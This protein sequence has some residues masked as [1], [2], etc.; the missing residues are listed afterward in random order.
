MSRR[1]LAVSAVLILSFCFTQLSCRGKNADDLY[2]QALQLIKN[3]KSAEAQ[4]K[5]LKAQKKASA[6]VREQAV[7]LSL[8]LK[9][10]NNAGLSHSANNPEKL[11]LRSSTYQTQD[12]SVARNAAEKLRLLEIKNYR[13]FLAETR[14]WFSENEISL[15]HVELAEMRHLED[16]MI[17]GRSAVFQR[18]YDSAYSFFEPLLTVENL[19]SFSDFEIDDI[20]KAFLYSSG[21]KLSAAEIFASAADL[22]PSARQ[23][24]KALLYFYAGRLYSRLL[25]EEADG[26]NRENTASE[27]Y[28]A[29]I[30]VAEAGLLKDRCMWYFLESARKQ[31]M[32]KA[33]SSLSELAPYWSDPSYFDDFL[34]KLC[35][36]LFSKSDWQTFQSVY[37]RNRTFF[38]DRAQMKFS[39][40]YARLLE[41]K[42]CRETSLKAADAYRNALAAAEK[43][44]TVNAEVQ[45]YKILLQQKTD[46][47]QAGTLTRVASQ[48]GTS[49]VAEALPQGASSQTAGILQAAT[50]PAEALTQGASSQ[51]E[52][53]ERV[54]SNQGTS[55]KASVQS[56]LG[57]TQSAVTQPAASQPQPTQ[58][59]EDYAKMLGGFIKHGFFKEAVYF[60]KAN[61]D[62]M[63]AEA[64]VEALKAVPA[65]I[66]Q[67]FYPE[68]LR[69][70]VLV[71]SKKKTKTAQT[72]ED[73]MKMCFPL[74]F[75]KEISSFSEEYELQPY[76]LYSLV[77]TESYFNSAV[78]SSAG[79]IGL[80]Q[81]MQL[82]AGDI[83]KKLKQS[84]YDLT[85]A[86][87]NLKFG[88]FY[89]A[90]LKRRLSG[91]SM[92]AFMAYNAGITRVRRWVASQKLP[93]DLFVETVPFEETREYAKKTLASG[94]IYGRLY[95]GKDS[96]AIIDEYF[97]EQTGTSQINNR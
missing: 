68:F 40:L 96:G 34:D 73:L 16:A 77:R 80:T 18:R 79:A 70:A 92:Q 4:K 81:L 2:F 27:F 94:V 29:S 69:T 63:P 8:L 13:L 57:A 75:E 17:T 21:N 15:Y 87:T 88:S 24:R 3:D 44:V 37:E 93:A 14:K 43:L 66:G 64:S 46:V 38:S 83:A 23:N 54:L 45:Y 19:Q 47:A 50:Q 36:D 55:S 91:N 31:S 65:A 56:A 58:N 7:L 78:I 89:L 49:P 61:A 1:K 12:N 95:Y 20:A 62:I 71:Y 53:S 35:A 60:I 86:E 85:E 9:E 32:Q 30:A 52:A 72:E 22:V 59:A 42:L 33:V 10:Q 28:R 26:I 51:G 25:K 76:F 48:A 5:L 74:F 84:E 97:Y 41:E 90:E 39:Y 67:D 11:L 6:P 82:T